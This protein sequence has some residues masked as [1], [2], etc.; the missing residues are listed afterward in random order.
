MALTS[1]FR[2]LDP[3][4]K[5]PRRICLDLISDVLLQH[6]ALETRRWLT[7]LLTKLKAEDFTTLAVIDPRMHP[8][9]ELYAILGLFGGEINIRERENE[10]GNGRLL[11][12]QKMS[13]QKYLEDE[14]L[15]KK[16]Q[17]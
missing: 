8:S 12:I 11:K 15:L 16:E 2:K 13:G 6:H 3:S 14:L 17:Q 1:A 4:E 7:A 5:R 9:E 10:K